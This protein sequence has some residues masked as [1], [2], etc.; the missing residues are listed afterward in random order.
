MGMS[1]MYGPADEAESIATLHA[2]L[3]AGITPLDTG[4]F[5]GM[6]HNEMLNGRALAGGRRDGALL[7]VKFGAMRDPAAGWVG[8]DARPQA[9]KS[10]L[11]YSLKRLGVGYPLFQACIVPVDRQSSCPRS[12]NSAR[13]GRRQHQSYSSPSARLGRPVP[14]AGL[15]GR[16]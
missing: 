7:S 3:E 1:G 2:A 14:V 8:Y 15:P 12:G 5:H 10:F 16:T 6:G 9:V 4:D 13:A 11:A